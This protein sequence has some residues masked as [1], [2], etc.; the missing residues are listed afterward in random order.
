L[1]ALAGLGLA[2]GAW[3]VVPVLLV[4][5]LM[6]LITAPVSAHMVGRATYRSHHLN[7]KRIA[8]DDLA[9][10]VREQDRRDSAED[11]HPPVNGYGTTWRKDRGP[12]MASTPAAESFMAAYMPTPQRSSGPLVAVDKLLLPEEIVY[13]YVS[14]TL[15]N[16]AFPILMVTNRRVLYTE[17]KLFRGWVITAELAAHQVA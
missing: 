9:K 14:G 2:V 17:R 13:E 3:V 8:V 6:Q 10:V 15:K 12:T 4:A 11:D 1:L 16:D 5:W 7:P